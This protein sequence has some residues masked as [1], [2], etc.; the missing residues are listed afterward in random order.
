VYGLH[1]GRIR[2]LGMT[3]S[4]RTHMG[5]RYLDALAKVAGS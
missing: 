2:D 4:E 5:D 1:D 3:V